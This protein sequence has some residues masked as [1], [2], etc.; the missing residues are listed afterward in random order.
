MYM[1][2]Q[3]VISNLLISY[4][5]QTGDSRKALLFLHGWRSN[6]EVWNDILLRISA[7]GGSASGGKDKGLRMITLDLP[8]FGKSQNPLPNPP[9]KGEGN[10]RG[11]T[12]GD[13]ANVVA[14]FIKKLELKNVILVGHSFGG[15]VGI[16]LL[17]EHPEL[18]SKLVLVD[19]AGFP[20]SAGKK[21]L[22]KTM[23]KIARPFFKP[24]FMQGF[25]KKIYKQIGAEDYLATPELQQTFINVTSEDLSEDMKKI[26]VPTLIVNGE[27]DKVTPV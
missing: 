21:S 26:K 13:Y 25:R 6:K 27:N 24:A 16:K 3:I 8:G 15:R 12:V 10:D 22:I 23:A 14:E 18:I 2:K 4:T 19:S 5:E 20:M 7:E 9:H 11:W 1:N 17:S